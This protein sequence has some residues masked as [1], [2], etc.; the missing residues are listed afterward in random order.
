L[1]RYKAA[2]R[3]KAEEDAEDQQEKE[4]EKEEALPSD[5]VGLCTLNQVDP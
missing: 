2:Q 3:L 5:A 1:Q 4:E